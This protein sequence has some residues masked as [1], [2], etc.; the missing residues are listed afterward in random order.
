MLLVQTAFSLLGNAG[1]H[2]ALGCHHD[3]GGQQ[4]CSHTHA[5]VKH[6]ACRCR[7]ADAPGQAAPVPGQQA[8]IAPP[9]SDDDCAICQFFARPVEASAEFQWTVG[10]EPIASVSVVIP[11]QPA[12]VFTWPYEVRGP[13]VVA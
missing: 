8:P 1:L 11:R 13:P 10:T 9:M 5:P 7:S 12:N 4:N 2:G 3:H 6:S